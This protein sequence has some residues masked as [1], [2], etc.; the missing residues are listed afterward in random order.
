[1]KNLKNYSFDFDTASLSD[2]LNANADLLLS[3]IVLDT[4]EA[5]YFKVIPNIKFGELIPVYETGDIDG[6]AYPGNGCQFSGG[7]ITLE[8]R[9]LKVCQYNIEKSW[10]DADLNRTIMSIRLKPG[11]YNPTLDASVEEA[12]M[13]DISRKANV[14]MSRKFWGSTTAEDGCSG[15]IEQLESASLSGEVVNITYSALTGSN[16]SAATSIVDNYILSL[17]ANL[18]TTTTILSLNHADYSALMISLR[19]Q[20]LFNFNPV[21]LTNGQMAIQYPFTNTIV[22]STELPA[23]YAVL[24]NPE[25]FMLGTDLMSDITSPVSWFSLDFQ[26]T[27]LRLSSKIGS[28]VG[29]ASQVVLAS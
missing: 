16:V 19:N 27:R 2:Y 9:E 5:Q 14:Y 24:T 22:I 17:P 23:G 21:E 15:I 25:N 28:A 13:N 18:K 12:F 26:Q 7:T 3:K 29:F 1:M 20:N 11:S 10:C 4:T 8:E 6:L